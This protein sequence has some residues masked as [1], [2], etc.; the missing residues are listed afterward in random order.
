VGEV[1]PTESIISDKLSG[2]GLPFNFNTILSGKMVLWRSI[3]NAITPIFG[4]AS[5]IIVVGVSISGRKVL[6]A[7]TIAMFLLFIKFTSFFSST[8]AKN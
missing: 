3:K 6:G 2:E 1:S 7:K 8:C 4:V 5:A